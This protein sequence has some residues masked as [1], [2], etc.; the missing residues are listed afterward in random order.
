[1][2]T[3]KKIAQYLLQSKAIKLEPANPFTWAS[4][5]KSPIY[6]DNRKTLSFPEIRTFIRDSFAE[7][8]SKSFPKPDVIAGVATGA[9]AQGALVAE[10]L[11]LPF[12]YVRSASKSHGLENLIEGV[13]QAG[14]KV[15]VIEDLVSTGGSSLKAV[16]ALKDAGCEVLGMAAIFTYGFPQ[17]EKNFK[18]HGVSLVTLS[19]YSILINLAL[20][21]GYISDTE[22]KVLEN[23]RMDPENW[24]K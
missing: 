24:K 19:N 9:I 10:K 16:N 23:W 15:V 21:N 22:A 11:N 17:A 18:D 5:W 8:I 14:Q 2:E 6:C 1:M 12:I 13:V 20:E 3:G 4:G 7:K